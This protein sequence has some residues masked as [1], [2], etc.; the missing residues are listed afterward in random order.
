[1]DMKNNI[2]TLMLSLK[3]SIFHLSMIRYIHKILLFFLVL[4]IIII[5]TDWI[6]IPILIILFPVFGTLKTTFRIYKLLKS[7]DIDT[8]RDPLEP[9]NNESVRISSGGNV[10]IDYANVLKI[11]DSLLIKV[12]DTCDIITVIDS[13]FVIDKSIYDEYRQLTLQYI[14]YMSKRKK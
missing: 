5:Y 8:D 12:L 1:M 6:V 13:N 2:V 14:G 10:L 11:N 4:S 9:S 3:F 7:I